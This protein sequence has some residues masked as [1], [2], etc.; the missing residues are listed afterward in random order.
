[1]SSGGKRLTTSSLEEKKHCFVALISFHGVNTPRLFSSYGS[2]VTK[3]RVAQQLSQA[4]DCNTQI[5]LPLVSLPSSRALHSTLV[6]SFRIKQSF[7]TEYSNIST[8][9]SQL[10][11]QSTTNPKGKREHFTFE[12]FSIYLCTSPHPPIH[13]SISLDIATQ[14]WVVGR[15]AFKHSVPVCTP[16]HQPLSSF[17]LPHPSQ[18]LEQEVRHE[19]AMLRMADERPSHATRPWKGVLPSKLGQK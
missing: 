17:P 5:V 7:Q 9:K 11:L 12:D 13:T 2:N 14:S 15:R 6:G 19:R 10:M 1:M 4:V 16:P 18:D 3:H 8:I